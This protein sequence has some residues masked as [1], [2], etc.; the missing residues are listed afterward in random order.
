MMMHFCWGRTGL[1][2]KTKKSRK[3]LPCHNNIRGTNDIKKTFSEKISNSVHF[4]FRYTLCLQTL[5][6]IYTAGK[7]TFRWKFCCNTIFRFERFH[8]C[9]SLFL[10]KNSLFFSNK[11]FLHQFYDT[12]NMMTME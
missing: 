5:F 12:C 2:N 10:I 1:S 4:E 6:D 3:Q 11:W 7:V 9:I 8:G